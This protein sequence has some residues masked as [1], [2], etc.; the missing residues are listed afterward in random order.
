MSIAPLPQTIFITGCTASG[1]S[2]I[3]I[4]VAQKLGGEIVNADA[5]QVYKQLP[6]LTAAPSI[7]EQ[8]LIPHHLVGTLDVSQTWDATQHYHAATTI[9]KDIHSRGKYAIVTGGSGLYVKFLSHGISQAPPSEESL[10]QALEERSL[11][12]LVEEFSKRDPEGAA[13]TNLAN[14]RYVV[15]NLEIILL[16]GK[17]LSY[18]QKNWN[19]EPRGRGYTLSWETPLL[20]KRIHH[21]SLSLIEGGAL[22]EVSALEN[23]PSPLSNTAHKTLGLNIIQAHLKNEISREDCIQLLTLRTRQYAKR[24]RTWIKR[25]SWLTPIPCSETLTTFCFAQSI[26]NDL[27]SSQT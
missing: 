7:E 22:A 4:S 12:S 5:Y 3:A 2:A 16:G 13:I 10:R 15:R 27:I 23:H 25:E 9:I 11:E 26:I 14:K 21:R 1:K 17:P 8:Q 6:L 18:W 20:D 19:N 24:Q